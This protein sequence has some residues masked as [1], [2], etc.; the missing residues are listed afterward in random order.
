M[1]TTGRTSGGGTGPA[2]WP[3]SSQIDPAD[4]DEQARDLLDEDTDP[5]A[6][7]SSGPPGGRPDVDLDAA[8]EADLVEQLYDVPFDDDGDR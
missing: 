2:P 7:A 8:S 1:Q 3:S 6:P 4:A 5:E